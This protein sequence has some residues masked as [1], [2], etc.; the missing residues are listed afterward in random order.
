MH[1]LLGQVKRFHLYLAVDSKHPKS[2]FLFC[3]PQALWLRSSFW[4]RQGCGHSSGSSSQ[5]GPAGPPR[6]AEGTASRLP[7]PTQLHPS[8]SGSGYWVLA[9]LL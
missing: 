9:V 5:Q 3:Q 2:Q 7:G 8:T 4:L 6:A 1:G